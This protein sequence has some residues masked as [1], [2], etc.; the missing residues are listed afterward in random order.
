MDVLCVVS[1]LI[2]LSSMSS[3][4]APTMQP[5]SITPQVT[6]NL[7]GGVL[8]QSKVS[9]PAFQS[10]SHRRKRRILFTQAC[11]LCYRQSK[12]V[13]VVFEQNK[14]LANYWLSITELS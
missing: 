13:V 11:P 8:D 9:V 10:T 2:G 4:P 12:I 5:D 6:T 14:K 3:V 1:R 7:R